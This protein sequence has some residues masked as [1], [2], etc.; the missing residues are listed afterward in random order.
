MP[1]INW[2][3]AALDDLDAIFD[4]IAKDAPPFAQSFVQTIM[5]SVDRLKRF[6]ESGRKIPEA[7]DDTLREVIFQGY[8]IMYWIISEQRIDIIAVMHGSRDLSQPEKQPW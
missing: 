4:L 6:P 5:Q 3:D 7:E 1:V 8:R 2:T